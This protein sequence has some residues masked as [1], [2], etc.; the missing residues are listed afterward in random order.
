MQKQNTQVWRSLL[1]LA[2]ATYA[3]LERE[4]PEE[5]GLPTN[6]LPVLRLLRWHGG[7][8]RTAIA[9]FVGMTAATMDETIQEM[10]RLGFVRV[11]A[12]ATNNQSDVFELAPRGVDV[13]RRIASAQRERI[14]RSITALSG[15]Q[16]EAAATLLETMAYNLIADSTGFGIT[17]AE[18]WAFDAHECIKPTSAKHCA[19]RQAQ[20]AELDP[21][22]FEGPDDCPGVASTQKPQYV[23]LGI[24]S[25][26]QT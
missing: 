18:C 15:D 4:V 14:E 11:H 24:D 19:F 26:G 21:D 5:A 12:G 7:K 16:Y 20:M 1:Q 22:I 17:C 6:G 9:A 25:G 23:E 8:T 10:L 13:A 3:V 2:Q